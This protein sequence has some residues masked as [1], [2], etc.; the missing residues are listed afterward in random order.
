MAKILNIPD[1]NGAGVY[2][3]KGI[4]NPYIYVGSSIHVSKRILQHQQAFAHN[5]STKRM[6]EL[7]HD[8]DCFEVDVLEKI[9]D[10]LSKNYLYDREYHYAIKLNAYGENGLNA[11]AIQNHSRSSHI[12][13]KSQ[14]YPLGI[15]TDIQLLISYAKDLEARAQ[16]TKWRDAYKYRLIG[17]TEKNIRRTL[18]DMLCRLAPMKES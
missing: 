8:D 3:I 2:L 14:P 10:M 9:P 12:H 13:W 17:I 15:Y 5:G 16:S 6:Q 1:Y 4:N 18:Q 11:G 7:L